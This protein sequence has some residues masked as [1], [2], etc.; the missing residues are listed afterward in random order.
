[1]LYGSGE[2]D[3]E[4]FGGTTFADH[5]DHKLGFTRRF[6][7]DYLTTPPTLVSVFSLFGRSRE[8]RFQVL[9][10]RMVSVPPPTD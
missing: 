2:E 4:R 1:M 7:M 8:E 9:D 10:G 6:L 3:Y 5:G